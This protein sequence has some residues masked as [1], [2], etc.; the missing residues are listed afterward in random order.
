MNPSD[1]RELPEAPD[2]AT[3]DAPGARQWMFAASG[4]ESRRGAESVRERATATVD[5]FSAERGAP[6]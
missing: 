5:G 1:R 6:R 2:P 3:W 4:H